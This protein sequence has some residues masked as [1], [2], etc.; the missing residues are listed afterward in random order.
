MYIRYKKIF[1][2]RSVQFEESLQDLQQVEEEFAKLL[3][4]SYEDSGDDNGST[5][6]DILDNMS[7]INEY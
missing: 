7:D 4:L 3:R 2:E 1:I 5:C 6:F